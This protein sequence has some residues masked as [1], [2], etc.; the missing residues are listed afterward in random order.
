MTY[1]TDIP[2]EVGGQELFCRITYDASY[3][4]GHEPEFAI[5]TATMIRYVTVEPKRVT[6]IKLG[7]APEWMIEAIVND[8]HEG[9]PTYDEVA[10]A[11]VFH[12]DLTA[13]GLEMVVMPRHDD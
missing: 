13:I 2:I 4:W 10:A 6:E 5:K 11:V 7:D 3:E 9:G 12:F 8:F 1:E